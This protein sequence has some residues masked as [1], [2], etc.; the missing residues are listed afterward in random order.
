MIVTLP[1]PARELFPNNP[2]HWRVKHRHRKAA[3]EAAW[4]LCKEAG[5]RPAEAVA[6]VRFT[7]S[8]PDRIRRDVDNC[9]AA[10]KGAVDGIALA[11]GIDDSRIPMRFPATLSEPVAGGAIRV[12]I[13]AA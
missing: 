12:E 7:F 9:I 8:P 11:L 13:I 1:W 6:E 5:V 3:K 10:S 2:A 4:A